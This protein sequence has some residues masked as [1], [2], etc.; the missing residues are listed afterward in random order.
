MTKELIEI[1]D[2]QTAFAPGGP[3]YNHRRLQC[4][5][6]RGCVCVKCG[7]VGTELR[8]ELWPDDHRP[9]SAERSG[10]IHVDLYAYNARGDRV[11][12]TVDHIMPK[13]KGGKN[14]LS[15]YQPMCA[16]C[17]HKKGNKLPHENH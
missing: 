1:L 2:I 13:S 11:L 12:M 9:P 15:N 10:Q 5:A 6:Q 16:P 17:N 14:E 4:F 8:K 3:Y 7:L